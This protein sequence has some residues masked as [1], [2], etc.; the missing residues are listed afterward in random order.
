MLNNDMG[1]FFL[2]CFKFNF[3]IVTIYTNLGE[4][5]VQYG[6]SQTQAEYVLVSQAS[7][8]LFLLYVLIF[9]FGLKSNNSFAR[10]NKNFGLFLGVSYLPFEST[11]F[12]NCD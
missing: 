7:Y 1:Y 3:P 8:L 12:G 6:I 10:R 9:L 11:Q 4:S 2:G 5:G